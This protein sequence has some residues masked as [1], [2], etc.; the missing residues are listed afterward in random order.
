MKEQILAVQRMQDF[1]EENIEKNI[2]L[3][4]LSKV[5]LFSPWY[6]YRLFK[7]YIGLTPAEY[8]R[9]IRLSKTALRLK[10]EECRVIDVAYDIGFGSVDG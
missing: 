7:N 2:S 10:K 9:K 5:S 1:I 3:S 8:I 4:D 6:S